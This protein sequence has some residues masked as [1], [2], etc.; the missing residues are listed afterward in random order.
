MNRRTVL[1]GLPSSWAGTRPSGPAQP[2][3]A[4]KTAIALGDT[5]NLKGSSVLLDT[6]SLKNAISTG[7][8]HPHAYPYGPDPV[9]TTATK[10]GLQRNVIASGTD[11]SLC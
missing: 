8:W 7:N 1:L 6:T 2:C 3:E 5:L 10:W 11:L 4:S 9:V